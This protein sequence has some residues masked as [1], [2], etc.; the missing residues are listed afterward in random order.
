MGEREIALR[1]LDY[2]FRSLGFSQ[3]KARALAQ[4]VR[5]GGEGGAFERRAHSLPPHGAPEL[6]LHQ[7]G[8]HQEE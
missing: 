1:M 7:E 4:D 3:E 5:S 2:A 6:R 8:L